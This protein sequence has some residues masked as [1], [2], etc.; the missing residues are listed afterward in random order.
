[1]CKER[2]VEFA[3]RETSPTP[4]VGTPSH[5]VR[6]SRWR[7]SDLTFG[8]VG[9]IVTTA[10]VFGI[11]VLGLSATGV[12]SPFG[13]WFFMGWSIVATMVLKQTWQRVRLD[14]DEPPARG[15]RLTAPLARRFP[16]LAKPIH[17]SL[18]RLAFAMVG[19]TVAAVAYWQGDT[20]GRFGIMVLGVMTAVCAVLIW[21]TGV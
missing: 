6:T 1:L 5:S 9:R 17:G 14:P 2:V 21:L 16:Q 10:V 18:V 3:P 4:F 8:P 19:I 12:V 15:A 11:L 13:L 20:L 7:S